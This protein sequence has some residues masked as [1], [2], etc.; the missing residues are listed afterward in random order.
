MASGLPAR[1]ACAP[2]RV[3]RV[4]GAQA[5]LAGNPDA[6]VAPAAFNIRRP[7]ILAELAWA[8][9]QAGDTDEAAGLAPQYLS[10]GGIDLGKNHSHIAF[11]RSSWATGK[12]LEPSMRPPCLL[13]GSVHHT[14]PMCR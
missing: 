13:P 10:G 1:V 3:A 6:I 2:A 9:W 11:G 4:A 8:R 14:A 7:A 5:A 12:K